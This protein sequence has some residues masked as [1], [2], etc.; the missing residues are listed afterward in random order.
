[1]NPSPASR[2][3]SDFKMELNAKCMFCDETRKL[4]VPY[5]GYQ[6][7]L[8]GY[9]NIQDALPEIDPEDRELIL[10]KMCNKCWDDFLP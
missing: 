9:K 5:M 8:S 10:S 2:N 7:W 6:Q 4:M 3:P 1:M